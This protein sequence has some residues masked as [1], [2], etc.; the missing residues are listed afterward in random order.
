MSDTP[1]HPVS[2]PEQA[3]LVDEATRALADAEA[4]YQTALQNLALGLPVAPFTLA[5]A[6]LARENALAAMEIALKT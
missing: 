1:R 5:D 4:A 2:S 6:T 3:R